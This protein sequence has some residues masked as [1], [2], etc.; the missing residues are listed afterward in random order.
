MNWLVKTMFLLLQ[1]A[2]KSIIVNFVKKR[3]LLLDIDLELEHFSLPWTNISIACMESAMLK[4]V[5][6]LIIEIYFLVFHD[7]F[8]SLCGG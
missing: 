3:S 5:Q 4:S 2:E 7:R 8:L 1:L 6:A